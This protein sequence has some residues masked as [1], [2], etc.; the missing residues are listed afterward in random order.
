MPVIKTLEQDLHVA[1]ASSRSH[2]TK[3]RLLTK[4]DS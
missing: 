1:I 3:Q 2:K 4:H